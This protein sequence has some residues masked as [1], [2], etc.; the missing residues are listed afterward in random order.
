M[1]T[2]VVPCFVS[3]ATRGALLYRLHRDDKYIENMFF[4]L[5]NFYTMHVLVR[6]RKEKSPKQNFF[7]AQSG[8]NVFLDRTVSIASNAKLIASIP[9]K[10]IQRSDEN[11]EFFFNNP[12]S[13]M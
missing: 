6:G 1:L 13:I 11:I 8:Y 7:Q 2:V 5:Q 12:E 10:K 3:F 4:W 9:P